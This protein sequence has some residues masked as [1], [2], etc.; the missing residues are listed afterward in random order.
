MSEKS[1]YL[2]VRFREVAQLV[3]VH[4]WG[5]CGR[6][7]ESGLPDLMR[8]GRTFL[9]VLVYVYPQTVNPKDTVH[10]AD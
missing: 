10:H 3:S 5:A 9:S 7:F 1:H 8:Q 6:Q 4:V 2:C